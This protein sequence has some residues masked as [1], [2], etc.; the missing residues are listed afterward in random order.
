VNDTSRS[1]TYARG[2]EI[3]QI[4]THWVAPTTISVRFI[5]DMI[6]HDVNPRALLSWE[7]LGVLRDSYPTAIGIQLFISGVV[8]VLFRS[9][10]DICCA[11]S[12]KGVRGTVGML[13]VLYAIVGNTPTH[14][15][16]SPVASLPDEINDTTAIGLKLRL[17]DGT[18]C[19]TV[20][21]HA[22]VK[23]KGTQTRARLMVT[24]WLL[25]ARICT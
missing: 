23:V 12:S 19:L 4:P 16:G 1:D 9:Y 13:P 15:S 25:Q 21:T 20:P 11:W 3:H 14:N 6:R 10:G 24:D 8:V 18:E 2:R 17:R 5:Q 7:D 22:F